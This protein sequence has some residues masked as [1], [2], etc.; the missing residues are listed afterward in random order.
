MSE[1][2]RRLVESK[3]RL[4]AKLQEAAATMAQMQ[5]SRAGR[6][7]V[8]SFFGGGWGQCCRFLA[9]FAMELGNLACSA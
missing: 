5:V 4:K 2:N 8:V 1:E 6:A 9:F 3:G 7:A